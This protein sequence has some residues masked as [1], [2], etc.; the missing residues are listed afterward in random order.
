MIYCDEQEHN[1]CPLIVLIKIPTCR[2]KNLVS[3]IYDNYT[4]QIIYH[5]SSLWKLTD[6]IVYCES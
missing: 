6:C 5:N 1:Q 4:I 3:S 2:L